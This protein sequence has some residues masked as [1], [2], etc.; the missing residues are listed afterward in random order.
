[1]LIVEGYEFKEQLKQLLDQWS[2][3]AFETGKI[4]GA[5]YGYKIHENY[6][7]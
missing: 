6:G 5:G 7:S 3:V 1:M 2:I 4:D